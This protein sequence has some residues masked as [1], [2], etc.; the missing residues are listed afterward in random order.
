MPVLYRLTD[1]VFFYEVILSPRKTGID[2]RN[3]IVNVVFEILI[4]YACITFIA[5]FLK[6][7]DSF[8]QGS[9]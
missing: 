3:G 1:D 2:T 5:E 9:A 7:I 8:E 6:R 4:F